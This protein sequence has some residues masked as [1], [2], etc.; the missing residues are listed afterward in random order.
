ME[1]RALLADVGLVFEQTEVV[2][3]AEDAAAAA[4]RAGRPVAIKL[5]SK[6]IT[7]K[8]DAGGVVLDVGSEVEARAAFESL[9]GNATAYARAHGFP[10]EECAAIVSPMLAPPVAE[11]LVGACRDTQLGP[12]LTAGAGGIWVEVLRDVVHRVLPVDGREVEAAIGELKVSALLAGAR[13]GHP[14]RSGPIVKAAMAVAECVMRWRDV[15]EVEVN[16]LFVYPDRV[17]P[18]DA[19]VVLAGVGPRQPSRWFEDCYCHVRR[20]TRRH[21]AR[22]SQ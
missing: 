3:S 14:V 7:H 20:Q 8:S 17:V 6:H 18:V 22:V 2:R 13:G 19:R 4:G 1:A 11:L 21:L 5:L 10:E 9:A 15:A 16:P 12:V